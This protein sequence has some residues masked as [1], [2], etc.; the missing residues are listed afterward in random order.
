MLAKDIG[1]C[2]CQLNSSVK[3]VLVISFTRCNWHTVLSVSLF[4]FSTFQEIRLR[5]NN[6]RRKHIA[7]YFLHATWIGYFCAVFSEWNARDCPAFWGWRDARNN[8]YW[9]S[10]L[11]SAFKMAGNLKWQTLKL[12]F[13]GLKPPMSVV[14]R[15]TFRWYKHG[16]FDIL[17]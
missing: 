4:V 11:P 13:G 6:K 5:H 17:E 2:A 7:F 3:F 1:F 14:S 8:R 16:I 15:N 12:F 9:I 10:L